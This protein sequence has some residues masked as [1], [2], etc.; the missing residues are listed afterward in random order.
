MIKILW[1][2]P[3]SQ[4]SSQK[5]KTFSDMQTRRI[6]PMSSNSR[7]QWVNSQGIQWAFHSLCRP[8]ASGIAE[9]WNGLTKLNNKI[10]YSAS[11]ANPRAVWSLNAAI[12]WNGS[13]LFGPSWVMI[14]LQVIY[15]HPRLSRTTVEFQ[16]CI[17]TIP[18]HGAFLSLTVTPGQ[19][20]WYI[21]RVAGQQEGTCDVQPYSVQT[22]A[23]SFGLTRPQVMRI[24]ILW[25]STV[26]D[27]SQGVG[28]NGFQ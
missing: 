10:F 19:P 24:M 8:Q 22:A 21:L 13:P 9:L 2:Q 6:A 11:L 26:L 12:S 3:T 15:L 27:K 7:K 18:G 14:R 16:D 28:Y 1:T 25:L 23:F 5:S 20:G 4:P 17:L